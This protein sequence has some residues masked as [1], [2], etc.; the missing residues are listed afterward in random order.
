MRLVFSILRSLYHLLFKDLSDLER[1]SIDALSRGLRISLLLRIEIGRAQDA[2]RGLLLLLLDVKVLAMVVV[3]SE[4]VDQLSHVLF[5]M[6]GL[7]P[8]LLIL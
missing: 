5:F 6:P 1:H 8:V 2:V 4:L 3:L 7:A